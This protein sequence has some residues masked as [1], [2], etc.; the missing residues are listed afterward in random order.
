MKGSILSTLARCLTEYATVGCSKLKREMRM[1]KKSFFAEV[2]G[3]RGGGG[4]EVGKIYRSSVLPNLQVLYFCPST[5]RCFLMKSANGKAK[6][7][8]NK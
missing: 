4:R 1:T 2:K 7:T 5:S 3:G 6:K 8:S